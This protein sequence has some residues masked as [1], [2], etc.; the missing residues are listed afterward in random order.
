MAKLKLSSGSLFNHSSSPNVDYVKRKDLNCIEYWTTRSI[1][2]D[3]ELCIFYGHSLW[4][5]DSASGP[6][7]QD[8]G[9]QEAEETAAA[10][11]E[12]LLGLD[13]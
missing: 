12:K 3:E 7:K 11:P 13:I 4:F 10:F 1:E 6:P 2:H 9:H 8:T 5:V